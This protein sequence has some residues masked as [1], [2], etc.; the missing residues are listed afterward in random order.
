MTIEVLSLLSKWPWSWLSDF[1]HS[2]ES[3]I[4]WLSSTN[5][6]W[7][8]GG[9][10]SSCTNTPPLTF[11]V[12]ACLADNDHHRVTIYRMPRVWE[13]LWLNLLSTSYCPCPWRNHLVCQCTVTSEFTFAHSKPWPITMGKGFHCRYGISQALPDS[14]F[15]SD[16]WHE[17]VGCHVYTKCLMTTCSH[18]PIPDSS[19]ATPI[20][21]HPISSNAPHTHP[22]C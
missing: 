10:C 5:F 8:T 13:R 17:S 4:T 19:A 21:L 11:L 18:R 7:S 20:T 16:S 3:L 12:T 22:S 9:Q 15:S 14:D 2:C 6:V 1:Q